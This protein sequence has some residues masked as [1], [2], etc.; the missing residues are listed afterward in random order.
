MFTTLKAY[1]SIKIQ[2]FYESYFELATQ[3]FEYTETDLK[4]FKTDKIF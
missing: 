3:I 4:K 1:K 2:K